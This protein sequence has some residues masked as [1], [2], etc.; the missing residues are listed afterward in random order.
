MR[1]TAYK[2]AN[3]RTAH[4]HLLR[5]RGERVPA[6]IYYYESKSKLYDVIVP[7]DGTAPTFR[8]NSKRSLPGPVHREI[9]KFFNLALE[10]VWLD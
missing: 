4:T 7:E 6:K 1:N 9:D 3:F 8:V 2:D 10:G 5:P